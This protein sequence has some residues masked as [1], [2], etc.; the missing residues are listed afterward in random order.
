ML[1]FSRQ[2]DEGNQ[3][4]VASLCLRPSGRTVRYHRETNWVLSLRSC[5]KVL[6]L[7]DIFFRHIQNPYRLPDRPCYLPYRGREDI[8]V[9]TMKWSMMQLLIPPGITV[10]TRSVTIWTEYTCGIEWEGDKWLLKALEGSRCGLMEVLFM[11][12]RGRTKENHVKLAQD[13]GCCGRNPNTN[14]EPDR[15]TTQLGLSLAVLL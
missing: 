1:K 3:D 4:A 11:H 8:A 14:V 10:L 2:L 13:N 6:Q 7:A 5:A 9:V 12:V 15:Q